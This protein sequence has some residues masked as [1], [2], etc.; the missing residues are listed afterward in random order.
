MVFETKKRLNLFQNL[1]MLFSLLATACQ[2]TI[3]GLPRPQSGVLTLPFLTRI[4]L[5]IAM[6]VKPDSSF[7]V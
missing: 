7:N 3:Y 6:R 1:L 2:Q 4:S 5:S